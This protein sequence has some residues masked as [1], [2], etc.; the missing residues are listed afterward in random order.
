MV[1]FR[2]HLRQVR[3][4]DHLQA[5][6][7]VRND[8][9][10][11]VRDGPGNAGIDF[12]ENNGRQLRMRRHESFERKHQARH[13]A[14]RSH[15]LDRLQRRVAVSR[16]Q[17]PDQVGAIGAQLARRS[18][19]DTQLCRRHTQLDK[20]TRHMLFHFRPGSTASGSNGCRQFPC[21]R[22]HSFNPECQFLYLGA[23]RV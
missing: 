17:E 10:H 19:L 8:L 22:Q 1:A 12:V 11:F 20:Q 21:T 4:I 9:A 15:L 2:G 16:K 7:Q 5:P 6:G 3:D 18:D 14:A 13:L 23:I